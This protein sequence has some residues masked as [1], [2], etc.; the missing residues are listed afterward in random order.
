[1]TCLWPLDE[2]C[3]P[4]EW[5]TIHPAAQERGRVYASRTL[6]RL[7]GYQVGVCPVTIRPAGTFHCEATDA[8]WF[9]HG[10]GAPVV[11]NWNGTWSNA[12]CCSRHHCEVDLPAPVGRV[13]QVWCNG[14]I[15][16]SWDYEVHNGHLLTWTGQG[17]CPFPRNQDMSKPL[18]E[19]GTMSVTYLNAYEPGPDGIFAATVLA[20]EFGLACSGQRCRLPDGVTSIVRQGISMQIAAGSFPDGKTGI[21]E[22]DAYTALWNPRNIDPPVVWSPDLPQHRRIGG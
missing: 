3:L 4:E 6:E 12:S 11:V 22:V 1:M 5:E 19:T 7:T 16:D 2:T 18:T 14:T 15:L 10:F 20:V 17:E 9:G 8:R 21:H 13:D